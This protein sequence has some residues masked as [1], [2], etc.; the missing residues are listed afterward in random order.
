MSQIHTCINMTTWHLMSTEWEVK[1]VAEGP[2]PNV[3]QPVRWTTVD[4]DGQ[5][6]APIKNESCI[7]PSKAPVNFPSTLNENIHLPQY[8][9]SHTA[10]TQPNPMRE[11][12]IDRCAL[13]G[14][15]SWTR[16]RWWHVRFTSTA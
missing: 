8:T 6:P 1:Y 9:G 13:R 2:V 14:T 10:V 7:I 4:S 11:T 15:S 16:P 3:E 12:H 5:F